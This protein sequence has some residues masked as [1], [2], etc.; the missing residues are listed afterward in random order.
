LPH[1]VIP[2]GLQRKSLAGLERDELLKIFTRLRERGWN[3]Q[4]IKRHGVRRLDPDGAAS[5]LLG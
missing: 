4:Q 1:V 5:E 2:R 3:N